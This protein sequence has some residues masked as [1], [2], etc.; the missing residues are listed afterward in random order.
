M[1]GIT[2]CAYRTVVSEIFDKHGSDTDTLHL[3]GEFMS[4]EWYVRNPA[5]L[6][7]HV[8]NTP[9]QKHPF[10]AQIYGWDGDNLVQTA[11]DIDRR[12]GH[13]FA[14]IELNI[15]CPSPKVMKWGSGAGMMHDRSGTLDIVRRISEA[16]T[17]PFSI[18]VRAWL[19]AD[20][21][22]D[23]YKFILD[24]AP[25]CHMISI[26]GRTYKQSHNGEVDR[27]YI[28]KIKSDLA[29]LPISIIGNGWLTWYSSGLERVGNLDGVMRGQAAMMRPRVLVPH[30]PDLTEIRETIMRHLH[31]SIAHQLWFDDET[32]FVYDGKYTGTFTQPTQQEIEE[33]ILQIPTRYADTEFHSIVEF[34]KHLFR[35]VSWLIGNKEFKQ[36][37]VHVKSYSLLLEAIEEL[38]S[39][40]EELWSKQEE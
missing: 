26:H 17:L 23:Q 10:I 37:V 38:W 25:Y 16:I 12:Y 11:I 15:G 21:K 32:H 34:R 1:D 8:V 31:L 24:C 19:T 30:Q 20:D 9:D 18:K 14:G 35:Y 6:V 13:V 3:F 33:I 7:R 22:D 27:E 29:H 2:D 40:Q 28:Y 4:A 5:R 39:K 36:S